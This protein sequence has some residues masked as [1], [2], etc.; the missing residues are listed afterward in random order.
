MKFSENLQNLRKEYNLSQDQLA[1]KLEVSRQAVSKW[2][3]GSSY[4]EMDKLLLLCEM[5]NCKMDDLVKGDIITKTIHDKQSVSKKYRRF[6]QA[7]ATGVFLCVFGVALLTSLIILTNEVIAV[8]TLLT[9]IL[10][11]TGI[12]IYFGLEFANFEEEIKELP[13]VYDREDKKRYSKTF[14]LAITTGVSLIMIGVILLI[15]L[16]NSVEKNYV[17]SLFMLIISI[18]VFIMVYYGI[19]FSKYENHKVESDNLNADKSSSIIMLLA[20]SIFL[21]LGFV[22]NAWHPAWVVFPI[23]GILCGIVSEIFRKE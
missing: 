6:A 14:A 12:F 3:S 8:A 16:M 7:M 4:P 9:C 2:E 1:E 18:A 13:S 17:V 23:G 22:K 5:F 20:T 10:V 11:A 21:Y 15:V 19:N